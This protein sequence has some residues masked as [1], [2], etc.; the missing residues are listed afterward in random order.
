MEYPKITL[1]AARVNAGISQRNAA[2]ALNIS[3]STLHNYELGKTVPGWDV[4]RRIEKLY[5][6]PADYIFFSSDVRL[7]RNDE[8]SYA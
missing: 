8:R 2:M 7:K 4:V 1:K 6:L 5:G 3:R